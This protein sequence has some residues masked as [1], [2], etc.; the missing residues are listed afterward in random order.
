MPVIIKEKLKHTM[1]QPVAA[2]SCAGRNLSLDVMR[3]LA[4]CL[5]VFSHT[6]LLSKAA[7]T[8]TA[9]RYL[10]G[11]FTQTQSGGW[12]GVDLF[13]VL[14]GF[15]VSGLLFKELKN[16]GRVDAGTFLIRRGFRIYPG[17]I[18][19]IASSY[20]IDRLFTHPPVYP[21]TDYVKDLL[22]LHNYRGGRWGITW[23]LDVEEAFYFL[24]AAFFF[25]VV[26]YGR[27]TGKLLI[28]TYLLLV[29]I[30]IWGRVVA[31][32]HDAPFSFAAQYSLTH[33][34]LDAL[35]AGV[36]LAYEYHYQRLRFLKFFIRYKYIIIALALLFILPNFIFKRENSRC[37][38]IFFL[39]TNPIAFGLLMCCALTIKT[40][41][42]GNPILAFIGRYS[43][44]IYLW[45]GLINEHVRDFFRPQSSGKGLALYI[46]VFY[47]ATFIVSIGIT[48]LI[49]KTFLKLRDRYFPSKIKVAT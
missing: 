49:E 6:M 13:F 33:F 26:R 10:H 17:F 42:T 31:N 24:L 40:Q 1:A 2:N 35:F 14:S 37:I 18:F 3:G 4:I 47:G 28:T 48:E 22:F 39:S 25:V 46:L 34:R 45:H 12:T 41:F 38:S 21:L 20:L 5:V 23:S 29:V 27:F 9:G 36:V 43:Y 32:A 7:V 15:L 19:F 44:A 11:L 8:S 30:G 16:T